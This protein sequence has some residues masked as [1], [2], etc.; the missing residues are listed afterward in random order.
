MYATFAQGPVPYTKDRAVRSGIYSALDF[1][2][3][4]KMHNFEQE[5]DEVSACRDSAS[6]YSISTADRNRAALYSDASEKFRVPLSVVLN[7]V[8]PS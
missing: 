6:M 7:V 3:T 8:C 1:T 5:A 2:M 4:L